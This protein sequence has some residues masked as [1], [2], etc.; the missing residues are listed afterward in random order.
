MQALK[1]LGSKAGSIVVFDGAFASKA[2]VRKLSAG[3]A[4]IVTSLRS[5]AKLCG[6]PVA[7]PGLRGRPRKYGK[8]SISLMKRATDCRGWQSILD[9]N[10]A[11]IVEERYRIFLTT[12]QVIGGT[13]YI[14]L[15][16]HAKGNW[17]AC[18]SSDTSMSIKFILKTVSYRWATEV[19]FHD[20]KD[21]WG[22]GEQQVR[23]YGQTSASRTCVAGF[24]R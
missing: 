16:E 6:L 22:E 11:K 2:L 13:V 1:A 12:R 8:I 23:T 9:A 14:V 7:T 15:L 5:N 4:I 19:H 10:R 18:I 24:I 21:I 20:V 3:A 17:A